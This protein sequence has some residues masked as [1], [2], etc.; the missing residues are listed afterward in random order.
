MPSLSRLSCQQVSREIRKRFCAGAHG[1]RMSTV[2]AVVCLSLVL[3]AIS[4]PAANAQAVYGSI[5]GT[6]IDSSG[7]AVASYMLGAVSST[8]QRPRSRGRL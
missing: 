5:G 6:V 1:V 3:L 8:P 7:S 4:I 2:L